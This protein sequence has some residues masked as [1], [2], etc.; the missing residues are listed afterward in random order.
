MK[1]VLIRELIERK[2]VEIKTGPFGT[3]LK[4]SE[5]VNVNSSPKCEKSWVCNGEY[6]KT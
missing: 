2:E 1:R 6:R 3:Q 4:A 5:Y